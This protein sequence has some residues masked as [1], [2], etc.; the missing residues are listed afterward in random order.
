[1]KSGLKETR[2][3][4]SN[5]KPHGVTFIDAMKSRAKDGNVT[6]PAGFGSDYNGGPRTIDAIGG[7]G[8]RNIRCVAPD[9]ADSVPRPTLGSTADASQVP[10]PPECRRAPILVETRLERIAP[11]LVETLILYR[12]PRAVSI[13]AKL[14][15]IRAL[16]RYSK[17]VEAIGLGLDEM[18]GGGNVVDLQLVYERLDDII[19][20]NPEAS[21]LQIAR[22]FR[23]QVRKTSMDRAD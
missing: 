18:G 11:Q 6:V 19:R 8:P 13:H 15:E 21:P 7:G 16:P 9:N 23:D 10:V 22:V 2:R 20:N 3:E 17:V 14:D 12:A 4:E 1:M 5:T